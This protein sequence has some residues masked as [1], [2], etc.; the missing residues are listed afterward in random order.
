[1]KL[2]VHNATQREALITHINTIKIGDFGF[3]VEIKTGTR[4]LKQNSSLWLYFRLLADA[5]ND[6]GLEV[7]MEYLGKS[8]ELPWN[9]D[10]VKERLWMPIQLAMFKTTSTTKLK[11][12][13]VS[14]V[15]RTL[16][17]HLL[18]VHSVTVM[19]PNKDFDDRGY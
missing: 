9:S 3:Q 19:F 5:L 1:M 12:N 2:S 7:H 13:E 16:D 14:E 4:T 10:M 6:A 15:Y 8:I 17:R 11:R 18:E